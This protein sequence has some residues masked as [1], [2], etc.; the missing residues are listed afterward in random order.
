MTVP[1]PFWVSISTAVVATNV[2]RRAK[3][4]SRAASTEPSIK[5]TSRGKTKANSTAAMACRAPQNCL[6]ICG[7]RST[8]WRMS[9]PSRRRIGRL[10]G[11]VLE[12]SGGRNELD[13]LSVKSRCYCGQPDRT[14]EGHRIKDLQIHILTTAAWAESGLIVVERRHKN[15]GLR[16]VDERIKSAR[17][18]PPRK[19][20]GYLR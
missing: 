13:R 14:N 20:S 10:I 6:K 18:R 17:I 16:G 12:G 15:R 3:V 5:M 4:I 7:M 11:L 19:T 8:S 2:T 9:A 1:V